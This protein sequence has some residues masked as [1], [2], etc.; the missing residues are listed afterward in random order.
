MKRGADILLPVAVA[1]LLLGFWQWKVV[2]DA[3][4]PYV[5]PAPS[6]IA[7]ALADNFTSLMASLWTTLTVTLLAFAWSVRCIARHRLRKCSAPRA[8]F[9]ARIEENAPQLSLGRV[10]LR[11]HFSAT[12]W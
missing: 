11:A 12:G 10:F 9:G 4:P 8:P 1:A 2:H 6:A 3:I 7:R 5:L